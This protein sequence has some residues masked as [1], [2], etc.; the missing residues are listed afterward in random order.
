MHRSRLKLVPSSPVRLLS[1]PTATMGSLLTTAL[2]MATI[3]LTISPAEYLSARV[4]GSTA[5][6][7]AASDRGLSSVEVLV[8]AVPVRADLTADS[9][10]TPD[11]MA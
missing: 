5:S 9:A 10:A 3:A 4:R 11:S 8:S 7:V 2:L 6:M 1:A